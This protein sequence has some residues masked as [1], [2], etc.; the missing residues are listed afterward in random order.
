[1][2]DEKTEYSNGMNTPKQTCNIETTRDIDEQ[3][4]Q[5]EG[6]R[7]VMYRRD[8]RELLEIRE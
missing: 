6:C 8:V 3:L 5:E 4:L 7:T 2:V 1:M